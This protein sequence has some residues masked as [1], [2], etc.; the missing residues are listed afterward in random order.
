MIRWR[1]VWLFI[2]LV[3]L[4]M[5]IVNQINLG[6]KINPQLYPLFILVLPIR[7]KGWMLLLLAFFLGLLIDMLSDSLAIHAAASVFVAFCR[8]AVLHLT[9]GPGKH[10]LDMDPSFRSMGGVTLSIYT[11][12]LV[13]LHHTML[14]FLEIFR[15]TE[16][17]QTMS[18]IFL[19][20]IFSFLF[21][22]IAFA[23][24]ER[25]TNRFAG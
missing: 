23:I 19:S 10:D 21:L 20:A 15:F 25:N 4:Q 8:P 7:I 1:F 3:A 16:F 6:G 14:F 11:I 18:R 13:L 5:L 9:L 12:M 22:M 17:S 2:L 24:L